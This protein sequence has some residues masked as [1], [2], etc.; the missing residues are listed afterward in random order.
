MSINYKVIPRVN[1][2]NRE[3]APKY[4]ASINI[5][6]KRDLRYIAR[7]IADRSS[8]NA[9]DILS[10]IEGFLQII[11]KT[12]TDGYKVDLGEFGTLNLMAKSEGVESE[13]E[14][15]ATHIENVKVSFRPGKLFQKELGSADFTKIASK[16]EIAEPVE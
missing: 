9:M 10:T 13:K 15:N 12:L 14:F 1:P 16:E 6:G 4:Y 7:E 11:P 5:K 2:Q 3:A 8:L